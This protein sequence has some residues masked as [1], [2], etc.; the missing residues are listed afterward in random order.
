MH[1]NEK[2]WEMKIMNK[3]TN[4]KGNVYQRIFYSRENIHS[5]T[6]Q[7]TICLSCLGAF[8]TSSVGQYASI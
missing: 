4:N 5:K 3:S 8:L 7:E 6:K 1:K 2:D